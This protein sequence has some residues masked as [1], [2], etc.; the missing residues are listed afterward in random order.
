M[1][2]AVSEVLRHNGYLRATPCLLPSDN[3]AEKAKKFAV[4]L[5][6]QSRVQHAG[7]MYRRFLL[8]TLF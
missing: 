7:L 4:E 3:L 8:D 6:G 1:D 2:K 5:H